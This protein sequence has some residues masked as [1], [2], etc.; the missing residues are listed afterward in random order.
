[1]GA[2]KVRYPYGEF[3]KSAANI[4]VNYFPLTRVSCAPVLSV[5]N[6]KGAVRK[7]SNVFYFVPM[8]RCIIIRPNSPHV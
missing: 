3:D 2:V 1:M 4:I 8:V 7:A 6:S 5:C